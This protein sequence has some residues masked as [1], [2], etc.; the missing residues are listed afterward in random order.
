MSNY[1]QFL[2]LNCQGIRQFEK[3]ARLKQYILSQKC[4]ILLLSETHI[5]VD[6]ENLIAKEFN[7]WQIFHSFGSSNSRGCSIFINK[8]IHFD[9]IDTLKDTYGRYLLLNITLD[10]NVYTILNIYAHN[11]LSKRNIFFHD[12]SKILNENAQG[13]I[14]VGG[15]MNDILQSSDRFNVNNNIKINPGKGF[16][17][18]IKS[19]N[20][21]DVWK[22]FNENKTQFTWRRKNGTEK[23]RIDFWLVEENAVPLVVKSDIRPACIKYTDHQAIFLKLQ[24]PSKRGNGY[25]KMNISYLKESD[26]KLLIE[27]TIKQCELAYRNTVSKTDFWELC[28]LEIKNASITYSKRRAKERKE[29]II[30]LETKLKILQNNSIL[31]SEQIEKLEKEIQELY[32]TKAKGAQIRSRINFIEN[33]EKNTKF[34]FESGKVETNAEND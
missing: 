4:Q 7:E 16:A 26:Y 30:E 25:W 13:Y 5:T 12:L 15:D 23:S 6:I 19:N 18:F 11:E 29:Y 2:S 17:N 20:L 21:I 28:K 10:N 3:R 31:E 14:I 22:L 1:I 24:Q 32:E 33:G 27:D 8:S 34:F 9:I